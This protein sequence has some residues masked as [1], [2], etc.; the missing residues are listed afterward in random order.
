MI[1]GKMDPQQFA[2]FQA[3][4][5]AKM[6]GVNAAAEAKK[7][8]ALQARLIEA[9]RRAGSYQP[10]TGLR[11]EFAAKHEEAEKAALYRRNFRGRFV[12]KSAQL[13]A[14]KYLERAEKLG[15]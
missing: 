2:K 3:E 6:A 1:V 14:Q 13:D 7:K 5:R 8:A 12:K 15:I 10:F 4:Y 9:A 11:E